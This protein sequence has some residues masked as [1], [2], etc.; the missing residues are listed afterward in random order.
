MKIAVL[1]PTFDSDSKGLINKWH[2]VVYIFNG[3]A[4]GYTVNGFQRHA[5]LNL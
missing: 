4:K 2:H 3:K 1:T 5:F